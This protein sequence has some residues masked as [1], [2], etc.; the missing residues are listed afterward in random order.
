AFATLAG[1]VGQALA[2]PI[3]AL[4]RK[5][6]VE[7]SLFNRATQTLTERGAAVARRLG[8]DPEDLTGKIGQEFAKAYAKTRSGAQAQAAAQ[9]DAQFGIPTTLGQRSKDPQALMNEKNM[10]YGVYGDAAKQIMTDFDKA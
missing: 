6:I 5:F 9:T 3:D 7:P 4:V 2:G 10:R 8:I 1:G